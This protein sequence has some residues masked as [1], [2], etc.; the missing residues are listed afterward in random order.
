[1]S[2]K[3]HENRFYGIKDKKKKK[4]KIDQSRLNDETNLFPK[5]VFNRYPP[6]E[7]KCD[8]LVITHQK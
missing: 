7:Y 1:M 2:V 8:N 3:C 6:R 5:N 4:K